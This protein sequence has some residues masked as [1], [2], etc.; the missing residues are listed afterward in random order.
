MIMI[1]KGLKYEE[2][3][4]ISSYPWIRDPH[5]LLNCMVAVAILKTTEKRLLRNRDVAEQYKDQMKEMVAKGVSRKISRQEMES[6][7]GPCHCFSS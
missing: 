4:W 6:Y 1:E 2:N 3:H 5:D 7:K